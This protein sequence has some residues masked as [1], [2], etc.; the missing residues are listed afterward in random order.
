VWFISVASSITLIITF[1]QRLLP[2]EASANK[3]CPTIFQCF[4]VH[5]SGQGA[6]STT[7]KTLLTDLKLPSTRRALVAPNAKA[8]FAFAVTRS[9]LHTGMRLQNAF[10][11]TGTVTVAVTRSP[12]H[13]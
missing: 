12:F 5:T 7:P 13:L 4:K 3:L 11:V 9:F 8:A 10:K 1:L 6:E 2:V